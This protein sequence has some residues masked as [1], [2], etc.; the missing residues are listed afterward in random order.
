MFNFN[1]LVHENMFTRVFPKPISYGGVPF[2][3]IYSDTI[4]VDVNGEIE[5]PVPMDVAKLYTC[6]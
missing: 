2:W 3:T 4:E 1:K 5:S 6:N